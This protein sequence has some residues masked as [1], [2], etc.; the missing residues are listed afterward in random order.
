MQTTGES[1]RR[2]HR[3]SLYYSCNLSVSLKFYQNKKLQ[4]IITKHN[5][6]KGTE[7]VSSQVHSGALTRARTSPT[8]RHVC[9]FSAR[10]LDIITLRW[11]ACCSVSERLQVPHTPSPRPPSS[12][13][14]KSIS[15]VPGAGVDPS[16]PVA[17]ETDPPLPSKDQQTQDKDEEAPRQRCRC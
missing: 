9:T 3:N 8:G 4:N 12:S 17:S 10:L 16:G 15:W 7:S 6:K 2:V 14:N 1:G 11:A 5:P 13:G